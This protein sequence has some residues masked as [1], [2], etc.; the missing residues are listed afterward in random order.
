MVRT[1]LWI[2]LV[3]LTIAGCRST[4]YATMEQFGKHKRDLLV[5]RVEAGREDQEE[6]KQ[7]FRTALERF[8][9][10]VALE[11]TDLK[12][13]YDTLNAELERSET[14]ASDVSARIESIEKVASD[15]FEEWKAELNQYS[16]YD[17]RRASEQQLDQTRERYQTLITAMKRAEQKMQPV[18]S[19]FRDHV[20]FLKHNLNAQAVASLRGELAVLETDTAALIRDMEA[21]IAEAD[22]FIKEMKSAA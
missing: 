16:S 17:L 1:I 13:K 14:K 5:D 4:Y 9:D 15:L 22:T 6:A 8:N 12:K 21:A 19:A 10:V 20:L 2:N 7:Q 18:L 3:L 11:Q